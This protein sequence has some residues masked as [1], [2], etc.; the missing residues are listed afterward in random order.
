MDIEVP[1]TFSNFIISLSSSALVYLGELPEPSS[2]KKV[3]DLKMAKH[4]ID[5]LDMLKEKTKGNLT[6][7]EERL[8]TEILTDLKLK[9]V[10]LK[11]EEKV[12]G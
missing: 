7:D 10:K 9:Y 1:V 2:G 8:L 12:E 4:A 6:S 11:K 5:T 3:K